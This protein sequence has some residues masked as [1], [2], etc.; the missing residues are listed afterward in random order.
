MVLVS[1]DVLYSYDN[2][3]EKA[4][5]FALHTLPVKLFR[6]FHAFISVNVNERIKPGKA[7]YLFEEMSYSINTTCFSF[8]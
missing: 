5:G 1:D 4:H 7:G 8:P 6:S 2:S 3:M